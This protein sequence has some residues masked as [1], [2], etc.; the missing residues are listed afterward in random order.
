M[1]DESVPV[2][3]LVIFIAD[4]LHGYRNIGYFAY[5]CICASS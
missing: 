4:I 5:R 3:E 2:L 1:T